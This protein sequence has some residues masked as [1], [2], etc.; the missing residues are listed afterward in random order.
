MIN[1]AAAVEQLFLLTRSR[2]RMYLR[3]ERK[4]VNPGTRLGHHGGPNFGE[5]P[6]EP[7]KID[8]QRLRD[9]VYT[10]CS[11]YQYVFIG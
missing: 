1:F 5:R 10:Y 8:N 4:A 7:S 11:P 3:V 6:M 2:F 9:P